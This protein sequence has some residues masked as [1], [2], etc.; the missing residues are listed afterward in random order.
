MTCC[1]IAALELID[2]RRSLGH[3][4]GHLSDAELP[5]STPCWS[6]RPTVAK[7]SS[8]SRYDPATRIGLTFPPVTI[9]A[10]GALAADRCR[11]RTGDASIGHHFQ[12]ILQPAGTM[13]LFLA[14]VMFCSTLIE[15]SK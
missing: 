15:G 12:R 1:L 14:S 10:R 11:Q 5:V 3:Q 9:S 13:M 4:R 2:P 8:G 6:K 7:P